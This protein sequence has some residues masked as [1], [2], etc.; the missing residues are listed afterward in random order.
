MPTST[1]RYTDTPRPP[2]PTPSPSPSPSATATPDPYAGLTI[3]DLLNRSYGGGELLALKVLDDYRDFTRYLIAYPSD[4][5]NIFGFMNVPKQGQPPFPVV[6]AIHGYVDPANYKTLDY[7]TG[8]ADTL[9]QAGFLVIHPNLRDY[10][11]SD[12]APSD[13]R[14]NLFRVGMAIDVLNLISLVKTQAGQPGPLESADSS[15]LGLWG[16]SMGGGISIRVMTV[17]T[18]VKAVVLYGAMSGDEKLNY[19]A[20]RQWS[21]GQGGQAE[22]SV[23]DEDLQ[24]ISP[25]HHLENVQ[26]AVSIHHGEA[27]PTVPL[28]WSLDLCLQLNDLG[29][30]VECYTYPGQPHVFGPQGSQLFMERVIE[31]YHQHLKLPEGGG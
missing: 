21:A 28:E 23:P 6:I 27:D 30:T 2:S 15:R 11:P 26:A 5:L 31:F 13:D 25:I 14:T 10:P 9:A 29:K 1:H 4:G 24:R 8:Y 17:S 3:A 20:V 16:H 7:T 18:D 19:E 12:R 22:L